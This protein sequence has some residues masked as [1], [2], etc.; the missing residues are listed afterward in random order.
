MAECYVSTG[1]GSLSPYH[2]EGD[3]DILYQIGPAKFGCRTPDG[4]FD[5]PVQALVGWLS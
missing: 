5:E 1:E 4:Q 2:V 3:A